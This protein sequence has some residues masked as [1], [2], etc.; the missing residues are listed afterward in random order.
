[1]SDLTPL[2]HDNNKFI[3]GHGVAQDA[4]GNDSISSSPPCMARPAA[5]T[6]ASR[7]TRWAPTR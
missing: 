7:R 6:P 4:P 1:M 3:T 2:R 5:S